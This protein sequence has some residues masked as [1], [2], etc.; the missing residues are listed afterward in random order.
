MRLLNVGSFCS[1]AMN[2]VNIPV[3]GHAI[4]KFPIQLA[5]PNKW[6]NFLSLLTLPELQTDRLSCVSV[7]GRL[8]DTQAKFLH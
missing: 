3:S 5:K 7:S 8:V 6:D 2:K 1:R 4:A